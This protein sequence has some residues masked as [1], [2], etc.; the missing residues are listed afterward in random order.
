MAMLFALAGLLLSSTVGFASAVNAINSL[1][2]APPTPTP[3]PDISTYK[4]QAS[5]SFKEMGIEETALPYPSEAKF[6]INLPDYWEIAGDIPN[7]YLDI[8]Y[9]MA[10]SYSF[11]AGLVQDERIYTNYG[12]LET[13]LRPMVEIYI[14]EIFVGSFYPEVGEDLHARVELPSRLFVDNKYYNPDMLFEVAIG[15]YRDNSYYCGYDGVLTIL[16]TSLASFAFLVE[17][18]ERDLST[19]SRSLVQSSF[20]PESLYIILP[21]EFDDNTLTAAATLV[22]FLGVAALGNADIKTIRASDVMPNM[23]QNSSAVVIGVPEEHE[24]IKSLLTKGL[25]PVNHSADGTII[26]NSAPLPPEYGVVELLPSDVNNT[27]SYLVVSG[28]SSEGVL[29]SAREL[30][31][32]SET[33]R[34]NHHIFEPIN[35][36]TNPS[37]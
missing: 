13:T 35:N 36:Y 2:D 7:T 16:D 25:L 24:F 15:F 27:Y 18:A 14:N 30:A 17:P 28:N 4:D 22:D 1:Q 26:K 32:S 8:N 34:Y 20:I 21:D 11:D 37:R 31:K 12:F 5:F 10:E 19:Y 6:D 3:L 23:L 33:L 9:D 29:F